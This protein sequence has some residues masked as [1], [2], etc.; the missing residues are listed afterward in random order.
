M[1]KSN[2]EKII[3]LFEKEDIGNKIVAFDKMREILDIAID[4]KK[5]ELQSKF[6]DFEEIKQSIKKQ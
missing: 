6:N 1:A 3:S 4:A 2:Y 5:S